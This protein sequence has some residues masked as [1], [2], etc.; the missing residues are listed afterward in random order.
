MRSILGVS[1]AF[2]AVYCFPR[3]VYAMDGLDILVDDSRMESF[4]A[5]EGEDDQLKLWISGIDICAKSLI[6]TDLSDNYFSMQPVYAS[7]VD[8]QD[9]KLFCLARVEIEDQKL[10]L[11]GIL[12]GWWTLPSSLGIYFIRQE[13][14]SDLQPAVD[15][16]HQL[17]FNQKNMD[18][19]ACLLI[20]EGDWKDVPSDHQAHE[21][22]AYCC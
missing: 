8:V 12:G 14:C 5:P 15:N 11:I 20:E 6:F 10:R 21:R 9:Y 19:K 18:C 22:K 4:D 3:C 13:Q 2:G 16:L 17:D 1:V 7:K